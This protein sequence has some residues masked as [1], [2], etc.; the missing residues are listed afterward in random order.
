[1]DNLG[2]VYG[3]QGR[4]DDGERMLKQALDLFDRSYGNN[5]E[6]APNYDKM[7]NDLGNL[8]LD[9]GRLADAEATMSRSLAITRARHGEAHPNVA[10]TMGNLATVLEHEGRYAEA[11]KLYQHALQAYERIFGPNHATTAIGLNNLANVY[12]AQGRN[13]RRQ[14]FR[15]ACSPSTRRLLVLTAPMSGAP[16]TISRIVTQRWGAPRRRSISTGG[17]WP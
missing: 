5:A 14:A 12:A 1:M 11:E 9:A 2:D 6:A 13:K 16:S 8:Y 10:G 15:S 4:F 7:L 17:R 3:L